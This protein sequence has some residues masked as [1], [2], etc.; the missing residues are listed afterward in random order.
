MTA[1]RRPAF[2]PAWRKVAAGWVVLAGLLAAAFWPVVVHRQTLL[3]LQAL[4][5]PD[6]PWG[7]RGPRPA[8]AYADDAGSALVDVPVTAL[9]S[10][11]WRHG[12]IPL[13]NPYQGAG[14]PLL[15]SPV[16]MAC[17][18]MR[19]LLY[20]SPTPRAW[21]LFYLARLLV[22]GG[23][24]F[25]LCLLLG[26]GFVPALVGGVAYM[27][28]GY[29]VWNLNMSHLDVE[30]WLPGLLTGYELLRSGAPRS[31][32]LLASAAGWQM[33]LGGNPQALLLDG[34]LAAGWLLVRVRSMPSAGRSRVAVAAALACGVSAGAALFHWLPFLE[35]FRRAHHIH[36]PGGSR[37]SSAF[38][39]PR[40]LLSLLGGWAMERW[41]APY[42]CH[43]GVGVLV[44]AAVAGAASLARRGSALQRYLAAV[45]VLELAKIFG[46]P[47]VNAACRLPVLEMVWF[48]KYVAPL[49]LALAILAGGGAATAAAYAPRR[50]RGAARCVLLAVVWGELAWLRPG[51]H[52]AP[53]DPLS[54]PPYIGW[55]SER[56]RLEPGIRVCGLAGALLPNAGSAFRLPD[57]QLLEALVDERQF[58]R[59]RRTLSTDGAG[60]NEMS[61]ILWNLPAR[62]VTALAGLGV[63]YLV[64]RPAWRPETGSG[65]SLTRVYHREVAIWRL[66]GTRRFEGFAQRGRRAF[67][68]G[69]WASGVVGLGV[70]VVGV[71]WTSPGVHRRRRIHDVIT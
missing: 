71:L 31:G 17:S 19:A 56:V 11:E 48:V 12:R 24:T 20:W 27:L 52:P 29:L 57:V 32:F 45:V 69:L 40:A 50:L 46:V 35:F 49:V 7:Y 47:L 54:P 39:P 61:L 3:P 43:A 2:P 15:A 22:A 66:S 68:F 60:G 36:V 9:V 26:M 59:L 63:R 44:L 58:D 64:T 38:E 42:F 4:V 65:S 23:W 16:M 5:H 1:S 25:T 28:S 10:D 21:D 62:R 30:V 33:A 6:G 8:P 70:L 14:A 51:P 34:L 55:L 41:H 13:W 67:A 37:S 53:H 18:P